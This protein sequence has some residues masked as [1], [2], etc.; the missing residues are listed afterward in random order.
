MFYIPY[1]YS[2]F[3][4]NIWNRQDWKHELLE[5]KKNFMQLDIPMIENEILTQL[6]PC[7]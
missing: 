2:L 5:E 1:M 7:N 3:V 6:F 4:M